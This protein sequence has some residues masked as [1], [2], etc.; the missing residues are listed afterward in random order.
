MA[1]F[2]TAK[3]VEVVGNK[4]PNRPVVMGLV[5]L[6]TIAMLACCSD[7]NENEIIQL[8]TF[9]WNLTGEYEYTTSH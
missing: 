1:L 9:L 4:F 3:L 2:P 7:T 6:P 8:Q 5:A